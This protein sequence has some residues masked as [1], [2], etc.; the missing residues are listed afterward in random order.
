MSCLPLLLGWCFLVTRPL[1]NVHALGARC[2][3]DHVRQSSTHT[4]GSGCATLAA[5]NAPG[6][7]LGR[8]SLSNTHVELGPWWEV[9]VAAAAMPHALAGATLPITVAVWQA[10]AHTSEVTVSASTAA[11]PVAATE[12]TGGGAGSGVR[13]FTL[14]STRLGDL[15]SVRVSGVGLAQLRLARVQVLVPVAAREDI[16]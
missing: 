8:S 13:V 12:Q 4:H 1:N 14:P 9:D 7:L 5:I 11:G 10:P 3:A 6:C 2:R 16:G 15:G